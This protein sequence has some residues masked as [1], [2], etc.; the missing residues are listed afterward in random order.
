MSEQTRPPRSTH[1][2][3]RGVNERL[4]A[5]DDA[6]GIAADGEIMV[7]CECS[8]RS[9]IERIALRK[10]RYEELRSN[11]ETAIVLPG[12]LAEGARNSFDGYEL[13]RLE[14]P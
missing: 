14:H 11:T 7:V 9:C 13:V 8:Q 12:H 1:T 4:Y 5:L 2:V 3:F 6:L 10:D